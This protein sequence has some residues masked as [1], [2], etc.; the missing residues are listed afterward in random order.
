ML[1]MGGWF[2]SRDRRLVRMWEQWMELNEQIFFSE[3][4]LWKARN[5][6]WA[7]STYVLT[8]KW[9]RNKAANPANP[10]S[11]PAN[12]Q[13][14]C[15]PLKILHNDLMRLSS[16]FLLGIWHNSQIL[17]LLVENAKPKL[18]ACVFISSVCPPPTNRN[19]HDVTLRL[20]P[21]LSYSRKYYYDYWFEFHMAQ[22]FTALRGVL[23]IKG[24][25]LSSV[26]SCFNS[27]KMMIRYCIQRSEVKFTLNSYCP[28]PFM[29]IQLSRSPGWNFLH[30]SAFMIIKQPSGENVN[31]YN[32]VCIC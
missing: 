1:W 20:N 21:T 30:K 14:S 9:L 3:N 4:F 24:H 31:S 19:V 8:A 29:S 17:I 25:D 26:A 18:N 15:T 6:R 23:V 12:G 32:T 11:N 16:S 2:S 7:A 5:H 28:A 27:G 13:T 10:C 22:T